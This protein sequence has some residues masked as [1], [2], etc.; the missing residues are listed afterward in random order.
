MAS[1]SQMKPFFLNTNTK[2]PT[3]CQTTLVD[4]DHSTINKDLYESVTSK[5]RD[6]TMIELVILSLLRL[7]ILSGPFP[8]DILMGNSDET[9]EVADIQTTMDDMQ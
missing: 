9:D 7:G 8:F 2:E 5:T 3:F 4:R 6:E 1:S